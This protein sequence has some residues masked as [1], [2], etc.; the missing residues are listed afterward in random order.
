MV[1]RADELLQQR[2]AIVGK[3]KR[4]RGRASTPRLTL[5]DHSPGSAVVALAIPLHRRSLMAGSLVGW[6]F[7]GI[8]NDGSSRISSRHRIQ[9]HPRT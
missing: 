3:P 4:R 5:T 7:M 9:D 1:R 6:L 2:A 8:C